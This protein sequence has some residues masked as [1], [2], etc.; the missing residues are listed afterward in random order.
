MSSKRGIYYK[1]NGVS[2]R[3]HLLNDGAVYNLDQSTVTIYFQKPNKRVVAVSPSNIV[4]GDAGYIEYITTDDVLDE[5]GVWS[6][7]LV[8]QNGSNTIHSD[9][10]TFTVLRVL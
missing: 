1:D 3:F 5:V 8:V 9:I 4:L 7:Q 6:Y 2:L 10:K